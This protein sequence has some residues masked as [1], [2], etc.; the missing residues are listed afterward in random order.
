MGNSIA[1]RRTRRYRR[2]GESPPFPFPLI[3]DGSLTFGV[4]LDGSLRQVFDPSETRILV[5]HG[6]IGREGLLAQLAMVLKADLTVSG[7]L[8]CKPRLSPLPPDL[9]SP[10]YP[11]VES[12]I[13]G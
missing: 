1:D 12:S 10:I 5:T 11:R 3:V 7:S 13:D 8:H 9:N 2:E 4:M 6:S